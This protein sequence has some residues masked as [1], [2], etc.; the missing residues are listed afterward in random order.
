MRGHLV[1]FFPLLVCLDLEK[2]GNPASGGQQQQ[3]TQKALLETTKG[4]TAPN[5]NPVKG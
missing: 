5:P 1:Y 3:S 4:F 2:S